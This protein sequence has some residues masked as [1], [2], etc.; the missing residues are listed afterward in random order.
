MNKY[1]K[2]LLIV[3]AI[4]QFITKYKTRRD[5][6]YIFVSFT[7]S[8][9]VTESRKFGQVKLMEFVTDYHQIK[10]ITSKDLEELI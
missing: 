6:M 9:V 8:L 7:T 4:I 10:S 2:S 1:I 5:S 3:N